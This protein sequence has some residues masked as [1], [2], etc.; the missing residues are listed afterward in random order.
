MTMLKTGAL[1]LQMSVLCSESSAPQ[2]C[3]EHQNVEKHWSTPYFSKQYVIRNKITEILL[4]K[5]RH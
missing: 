4:F 1:S 3:R 5:R 2:V